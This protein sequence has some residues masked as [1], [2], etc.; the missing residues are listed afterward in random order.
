MYTVL[1]SLIQH[2]TLLLLPPLHK[3]EHKTTR[4]HAGLPGGP[5]MGT[6]HIKQRSREPRL[7]TLWRTGR[8]GC[9][10][11]PRNACQRAEEFLAPKDNNAG[12]KLNAYE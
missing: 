11:F 5:V 10:C 12:T 8:G 6:Q 4:S 7:F 1:V 9:D 3:K 2:N